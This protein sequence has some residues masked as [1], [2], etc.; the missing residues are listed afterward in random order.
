VSNLLDNPQ[1]ADAVLAELDTLAASDVAWRQSGILTGLYIP[2][3]E[4]LDLAT[5]AYTRYLTPNAL[6]LN[7]FPSIGEMEK[8]MLAGLADLLRGGASVAGNVTSGG[9]E[10]IMLAVKAARDKARAERPDIARPKLVLPI[11]AHPAFHK[12]AHYLGLDL[13]VT[14]M[15]TDNFTADL[16]AFEAALDDNTVLAVGSAPNYSHGTV[17]PIP[18]MA[19]LASARGIPFHVDG[20][21]GGLYLSYLRRLGH[22]VPEFDFSVPGVTS[23]S[24]DLHKYGY[25]PKNVSTILY[26]DRQ[27]RA[28][29]WFVCTSTTEYA[30]INPTVQ[31]SR[32]GGPVAAAWSVMRHL[33]HAGYQ[34]MVSETQASTERLIA[35]IATIDGV[36]V[37]GSP[38]MAMLTL[39]SDEFNVFELDDAMRARGWSLTPQFACGGSP[40]NLHVALHYGIVDRMEGFA[41]DLRAALAGLRESSDRVDLDVLRAGVAEHKDKPLMEMLG[42]LMP[43]AGL[44][45]AGLPDRYAPLNSLLNLLPADK[46]DAALTLYLNM[47][48]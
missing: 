16:G 4:T 11:T 12:A 19:A 41:D 14:P 36:D 34:R 44:T 1:S 15:E 42:A 7:L 3:A 21:V 10:S 30:V 9:T 47:T 37:L 13:A 25:A 6:H 22:D 8:Q 46:R 17:D 18:A 31:S 28:H 27:L 48:T 5:E 45:G 2:E 40:E 43:L 38:V 29:A 23:I 39:A 24:L 26:K 35:E 20:C 32:T 33:G